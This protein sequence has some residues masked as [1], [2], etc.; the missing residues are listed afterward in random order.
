MHK[1]GKRGKSDGCA[2]VPIPRRRRRRRRR[3]KIMN[4]YAAES[5]RIGRSLG[6]TETFKYVDRYSGT[7]TFQISVSST[8]VTS[9]PRKTPFMST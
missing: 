5:E 3:T 6:Q 2:C 1:T 9:W 7:K 8:H 4:P